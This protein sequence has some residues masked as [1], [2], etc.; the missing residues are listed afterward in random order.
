MPLITEDSLRIKYF[1]QKLNESTLK[2]PKGTILTPSAKSYLNEKKISVE[3]VPDDM[4]KKNN[5]SSLYEKQYRQNEPSS[6]YHLMDGGYI[7][8]KSEHTAS[9]HSNG[10][11]YEDAERRIFRGKLDSLQ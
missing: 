11:A 2:L 1:K 10:L 4:V 5:R 6:K 7:D 3:F 9:F 8:E